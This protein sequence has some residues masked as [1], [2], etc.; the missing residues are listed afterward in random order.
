MSNF[1]DQGI[2][3]L[4][5]TISEVATMVEEEAHV[6]RYWETEFAQLRPKK[7]KAGK[8]IY[9][10][11]DVDTI[12]RIRHLLREEK[13]TLEGARRALSVKPETI[14]VEG[15]AVSDLAGV[16]GLLEQMLERIRE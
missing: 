7:N 5:Y 9:K 6:L 4:Y 12:F 16:R 3:K 15:D 8:R 11:A 2:S 13:Y 10:R 14:A 1:L